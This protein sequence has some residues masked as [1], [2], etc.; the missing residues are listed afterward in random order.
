MKL[1]VLVFSDEEYTRTLLSV[2]LQERGYEFHLFP[3]EGTCP[4]LSNEPCPCPEGCSCA[5]VIVTNVSSEG[6]IIFELIEEQK[7]SGCK[8]KS[9]GIISSNWTAE[10]IRFARDIDCFTF[11]EPF[12]TSIFEYWLESCEKEVDSDRLLWDWD[13]FSKSNT[14]EEL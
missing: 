7:R 13:K 3:K 1:R 4:L 6:N 14:D 5:D 2:V 10:T 8:I 11:R 9:F 12:S